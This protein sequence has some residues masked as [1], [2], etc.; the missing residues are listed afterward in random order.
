VTD[1]ERD[2]PRF[3]H[4]AMSV[5]AEALDEGGRR[6]I[7]DFYG[8]VFGWVEHEMMTEDRKCLVLGAHRMD[9][10][11]FLIADD[12]PMRC[13]RMDHFGMAVSSLDELERLY[14]R[15]ERYAEKDERVD[16]VERGLDDYEVVRIH[17]FYVGFLLPM[18]VEVQYFELA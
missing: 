6:E 16:L 1:P 8:E 18:M 13:P 2:L 10:F 7:V 15:A 4:V 14:E 3:N 17:N 11:V 5:P 12:E 9:Q